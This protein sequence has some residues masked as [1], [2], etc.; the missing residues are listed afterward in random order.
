VDAQAL[1]QAK[2]AEKEKSEQLNAT[3]QKLSVAVEESQSLTKMRKDLELELDTATV[4]KKKATAAQAALDA[5][6]AKEHVLSLKL[7]G[8]ELEAS[9][10]QSKEKHAALAR[11]LREASQRH[12]DIEASHN[13]REALAKDLAA[14]KAELAVMRAQ[15]HASQTSVGR[16]V[17]YSFNSTSAALQAKGAQIAKDLAIAQ[18]AEAA[19]SKDLAAR[20]ADL[21]SIVDEQAQAVKNATR[22]LAQDEKASRKQLNATW[23]ETGEEAKKARALGQQASEARDL[24]AKDANLI[25]RCLNHTKSIKKELEDTFEGQRAAF[26]TEIGSKYKALAQELNSTRHEQ[27]GLLAQNKD[28]V[29]MVDEMRRKL[30][31]GKKS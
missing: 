10:A 6:K 25:A 17:S 2:A 23:V 1:Q 14:A 8:L 22:E 29:A 24:I 7:Q 12:A 20:K 26:E 31:A 18:S 11:L 27:M 16:N 21:P 3:K 9:K 15:S 30:L 28:L 19:L 4:E 5:E 13:S